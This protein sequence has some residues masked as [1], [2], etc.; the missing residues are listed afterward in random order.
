[1][2]LVTIE[3][4]KGVFTLDQKKD[5]IEKV[6]DAM[7]AVEGETMRRVTWV[8]LNEVDHW[9]VGGT[10]LTPEAVHTEMAGRRAA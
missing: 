7:V 10:L 3:I 6:T 9:A 5:M 2:A 4:V 1:M 8:R